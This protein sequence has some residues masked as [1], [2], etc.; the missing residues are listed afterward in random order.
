[1]KWTYFDYYAQSDKG[2]RVA[3]GTIAIDVYK[4][5]AY[6]P[7]KE[8]LDVPSFFSFAEARDACEDHFLNKNKQTEDDLI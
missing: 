6:C 3:K 4:Y 5:T 8:M 2:Y 1:M 7:R